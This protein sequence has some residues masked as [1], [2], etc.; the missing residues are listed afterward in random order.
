MSRQNP[1]QT[2]T[3]LAIGGLTQWLIVPWGYWI[4]RHRGSNFGTNK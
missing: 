4:D 3:I 2:E 1:P